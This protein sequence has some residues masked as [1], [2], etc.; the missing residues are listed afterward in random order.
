MFRAAKQNVDSL[1]AGMSSL[2]IN[3]EEEEKKEPA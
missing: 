3:G 2:N 1:V